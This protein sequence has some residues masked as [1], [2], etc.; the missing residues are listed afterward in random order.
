MLKIPFSVKKCAKE[1][2]DNNLYECVCDWVNEA[3]SKKHL[4]CFIRNEKVP[5]NLS[6][7]IPLLLPALA[8]NSSCDHRS[9]AHNLFIP[10]VANKKKSPFKE[11]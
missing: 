11:R 9:P 6:F 8:C 7:P 3:C 10:S 2:F 5:D 4:E 1:N